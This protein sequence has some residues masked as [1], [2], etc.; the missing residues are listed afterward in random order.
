ME[1]NKRQ[2]QRSPAPRRRPPTST[3]YRSGAASAPS[4][5]P[6][7]KRPKTALPIR[8][9]IARFVDILFVGTLLVLIG[10][11]LEVNPTPKIQ[12]NNT[13]YHSADNYRDSARQHLTAIKDRNKISF[14][15]AGIVNGM[16]LDYPEIDKVSVELPVFSQQPIIRISVAPPAFI[17]SSDA[18]NYVIDANGRAI[19]LSSNFR[20]SSDLPT[21]VDQ[22]NYPV[23]V[24]KAVLSSSDVAFI[25]SLIAQSNKAGVK[26]ESLMLPSTPAEI[27]AKPSGQPYFVKFYLPGDPALQIG[28]FLAALH[29]FQSGGDQPSQYLDVRVAGKVFYK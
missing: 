9:F 6:F 5:S 8:R 17:L 3:Y 22:S 13:F 21:I 24:G 26:L 19:G 12:I 14:D 18:R 29:Q 20:K 16:M 1:K 4:G 25:R 11:S 15:E 27:D 23:T 7:Q 2:L 10:Y 28:Q